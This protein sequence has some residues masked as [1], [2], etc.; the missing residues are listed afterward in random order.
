MTTAEARRAIRH[1]WRTSG[2]HGSITLRDR[3]AEGLEA[4][5]DVPMIFHSDQRPAT[6]TLAQLY[7]RGNEVARGLQQLGVRK[8]DVIAV[9]MPNWVEGAEVYE[10]ALL[11]GLVIVPIIHIYGPAEVGFILRQS[12]AKLLVIPDEWR[13]IDYVDRI[14]HLGD[15][16]DLEHTIIVGSNVPDGC[17]AWTEFIERAKGELQLPALDGDDICVLMYTS[18]TTAEPKGVQHTHNS[19]LA[20]IA[21]TSRM[22]GGSQERPVFLQPFPAGHIAGVLGVVVPFV[23]GQ[24][25]IL[26]DMWNPQEGAALIEEHGVTTS[27]GTPFFLQSLLD[28]VDAGGYDAS[29]VQTYGSGGAGV[30]PSLIERADAAG[31]FAYRTYGSTEHP[32]VTAALPGDSIHKRAH[33]DGRPTPG[34]QVR[35]IGDDD[36]VLPVGLEGEVATIGPE[37]FLGYRD[38]ALDDEAYTEDGWFRTGDIGHLDDEGFLTITDRKKDIIIRG[39]ENISSKEVEDV[40]VQ[41]PGVLEAAVTSMPD[42]KYGEKVCAFVILSG[43][44]PVTLPEVVRHFESAGVAKQKTPERIEIVTELPRTL[45]GK[46]KKY[47]LR[48]GLRD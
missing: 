41:H 17:I 43:K 24:K 13:G 25:T 37:Q 48:A 2:M 45:A 38:P 26:M 10:A 31:W 5:G 3:I 15:T 7:R 42:Q 12:R 28:A 32:T 46:V 29:S 39:G 19:L 30:P 18:G 14:A 11:L 36:R 27:A 1:Q 44:D 20:E 16:P 6:R 4:S 22:M 23:R 35:I 21:S 9:Q 34:N 47:E 40:L 8:G 33:T